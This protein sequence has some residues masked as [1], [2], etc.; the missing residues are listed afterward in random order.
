MYARIE[1]NQ[2]AEY[3][4][5]NIQERC[6]NTSFSLPIAEEDLPENFVLVRRIPAPTAGKFEVIVEREP[7]YMGGKWF[8]TLVVEPMAQE[9][10]D[11]ILADKSAAVIAH[12]KKLLLDSDWSQLPDSPVDS[13]AWRTYRQALRDITSQP[14]FPMEVNWPAKPY[15]DT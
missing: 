15:H 10:V 12:R 8:Q 1:N 14:G 7:V 2:V 11:K 5:W 6:K 13:A 9:E 3:P 4:I